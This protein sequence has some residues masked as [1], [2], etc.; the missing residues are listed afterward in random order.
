MKSYTCRV[1][2][3]GNLEDIADR[4]I[5]DVLLRYIYVNCKICIHDKYTGKNTAFIEQS[6]GREKATFRHSGQ[7]IGWYHCTGVYIWK[8]F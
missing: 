4:Y 5:V 8:I 1:D 7:V 3:G 6:F 2:V